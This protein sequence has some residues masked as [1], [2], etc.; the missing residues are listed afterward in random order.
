MDD[1]R[2]PASYGLIRDFLV[3]QHVHAAH[4]EAERQARIAYVRRSWAR[5]TLRALV[6]LAGGTAALLYLNDGGAWT[7]AMTVG[8]SATGF[9]ILLWIFWVGRIDPDYEQGPL[10]VARLT[11]TVAHLAVLVWGWVTYG[12]ATAVPWFFIELGALGIVIG[13]VQGRK[14]SMLW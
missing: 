3:T 7:T 2:L 8:A 13:V 11:A 6:Y 14:Y 1:Y 4:A 10:I 12:P 9:V 5:T